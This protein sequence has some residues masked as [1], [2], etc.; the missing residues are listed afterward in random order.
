MTT[1][2]D[3]PQ[4]LPWEPGKHEWQSGRTCH[5]CGL[6]YTVRILNPRT[7]EME[8]LYQAHDR[9]PFAPSVFDRAPS[10]CKPRLRSVAI[11]LHTTADVCAMLG[12]TRHVLTNRTLVRRIRPAAMLTKPRTYLWQDGQLAEIKMTE[13]EWRDREQRIFVT[14]NV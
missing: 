13:R 10:P 4:D 11:G 5:I 14:A 12:I 6:H 7:G 2:L 8:I 3:D 1:A 9:H